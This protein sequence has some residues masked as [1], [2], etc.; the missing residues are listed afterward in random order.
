MTAKIYRFPERYTRYF[1]GYKISLYNEEEVFIT[2]VAMNA[3]GEIKERVTELTLE[4]YD[5]ILIIRAL[6]EA[7][8]SNL[9]TSRTK[10]IILKILKT[11]EPL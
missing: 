7:K 11:V 2:V 10:Q 9:F 4:N 1:N 8:S 3:F 5:P 6:S